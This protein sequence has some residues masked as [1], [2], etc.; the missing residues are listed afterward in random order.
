[1]LRK[2]NS[3]VGTRRLKQPSSL[4]NLKLKTAWCAMNTYQGFA[5]Q[6]TAFAVWTAKRFMNAGRGFFQGDKS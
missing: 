3:L 6:C 4:P 2:S 5:V 1:M